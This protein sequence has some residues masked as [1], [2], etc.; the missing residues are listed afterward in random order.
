MSE[1]TVIKSYQALKQECA[2]VFYQEVERFFAPNPDGSSQL[3]SEFG[4]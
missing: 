1:N 3:I 2:P 4:L